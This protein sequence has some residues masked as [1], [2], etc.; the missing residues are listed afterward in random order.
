MKF[1]LTLPMD[2]LECLEAFECLWRILYCKTRPAVYDFVE[3]KGD[4]VLVPKYADLLN[5]KNGDM[6]NSKNVI[7]NMIR[8]NKVSYDKSIRRSWRGNFV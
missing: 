5:G 8:A 2:L 4:S 1:P 3:R 7:S 6:H